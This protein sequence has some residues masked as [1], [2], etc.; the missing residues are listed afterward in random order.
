MKRA[1]LI[2][3]LIVMASAASA[4]PA[5]A[6]T[7]FCPAWLTGPYLK[8]T[9][10]G[11]LVRRYRLQALSPRSVAAVIVADTDRGWVSWTQPSV[12][13]TRMTYTSSGPDY[14]MTYV[15]AESPIIS[16]TF[17]EP[18]NVTRVWVT[19]AKTQGDAVFGWDARGATPCDPPDFFDPG[20][21][22]KQVTKRMPGPS[23]PTP[24]PILPAAVATPT[25]APFPDAPCAHPFVAA[26]VTNPVQPVFPRIV[27][28]EGFGGSAT[29][30]VYI[31]IDR[32]GKLRDAWIF[33]SSGYPQLDQAALDAAK[34][35]SYKGA[36]SYCRPVT[37]LYLF[38]AE[39][40]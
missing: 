28:D 35:S 26:T 18:V 32:T 22:S 16:V 38:R 2:G 31:A 30:E 27:V 39:F 19:V 5:R 29:T 4:A 7:E 23:D 1:V 9:D 40:M 20:R 14:K 3:A 24:A 15:K 12:P 21:L 34:K 11:S 36:T 37:G 6:V 33:A 10:T 8:S 17:P 25:T 13:L